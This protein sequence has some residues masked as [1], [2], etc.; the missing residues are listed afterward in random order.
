MLRPVFKI[1]ASG[2]GKSSACGSGLPRCGILIQLMS[3]M[4]DE[5]SRQQVG[6]SPLCSDS[7][8]ILQ[9]S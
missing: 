8:P 4:G 6:P 2:D 5:L 1:D 3:Q 7:D 9:P